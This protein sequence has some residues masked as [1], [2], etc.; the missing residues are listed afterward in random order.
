MPGG[1][2]MHRD[3]E[4]YG[5]YNWEQLM[6]YVGQGRISRQ[7]LVRSEEMKDWVQASQVSGLFSAPE[8]V[9][10]AETG[11]VSV[12]Q[13]ER[14]ATPGK[15]H[16]QRG[17]E[18]YGPYSQEQL[19]DFAGQGRIAPQ[20][21]VRSEE[22]GEWV[23]ASEVP[24][25]LPVSEGVSPA[26]MAYVGVGRRFVA[27]VVDGGLFSSLGVAIDRLA[28][29]TGF[30]GFELEGWPV[31][32]LGFLGAAYY[33]LLEGLFGATLGKWTM[34]ISVRRVDGSPCGLG[35]ALVRNLLRV[36][37]G[38]FVYLVGAILVW[39]TPRRQRV[40]DLVAGT[41]VVRK[42]PGGFPEW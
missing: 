15:W 23:Q 31:Y 13:P 25:L 2:F 6:E 16:L 17:G 12:G 32:L 21:L 18:T 20:D 27:L 30:T 11:F 38:L 28:G 5:P 26:E 3:G 35:P 34:G 9:S 36:V 1:W 10:R 7:D 42:P 33:V 14:S 19:Q 37:D 40:G 39:T 4:T 29:G 22:T 8:A 24:G 41:V